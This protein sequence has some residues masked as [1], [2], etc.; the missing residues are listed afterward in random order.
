[1]AVGVAGEGV[2]EYFVNNFETEIRSIDESSLSETI[3][4]AGAAKSSARGAAEAARD[5]RAASSG[6]EKRSTNA[7]TLARGARQE[8][9]SF[10]R[11]IASA[12][13]QAAEAESHI[14]EAVKR[15]NE[16]ITELQRLTTPRHLPHS[17]QIVGSLKPFKGTE[18]VFTEVCFDVECFNLLKDIDAVLQLAGWKRAPAVNGFPSVKIY[19]NDEVVVPEALKE[20]ITVATTSPKASEITKSSIEQLPQHIRAAVALNTTLSSNVSPAENTGRLVDVEEGTSTV[21]RIAVGRKP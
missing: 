1:M 17:A 3:K 5:A 11:D 6:A 15:A 20:G 7:L 16:A 9:D 4:E 18:Y 21:V 10:E 2:A 12:K 19:G 13:K 14:N 8:A